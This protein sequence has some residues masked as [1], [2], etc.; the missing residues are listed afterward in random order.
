MNQ[1][2]DQVLP[3]GRG[4]HSNNEKRSEDGRRGRGANAFD[5]KITISQQE[6]DAR[7]EAIARRNPVMGMISVSYPLHVP[8]V[9]VKGVKL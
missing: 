9:T 3:R 1:L 5:A 8:L 4:N 7:V 6:I 2:T